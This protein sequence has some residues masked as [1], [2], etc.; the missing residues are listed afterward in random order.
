MHR[1]QSFSSRSNSYMHVS[2]NIC[3]IYKCNIFWVLKYIF[4]SQATKKTNYAIYF[5]SCF[6]T[7]K[8]MYSKKGNKKKQAHL[9]RSLHLLPQYFSKKNNLFTLREVT[10]DKRVHEISLM[11]FDWE[12]RTLRN[13]SYFLY[14]KSCVFCNFKIKFTVVTK[15]Q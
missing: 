8:T 10:L 9:L 4:L 3:Y 13:E 1:E 5:H 14:V 11:H 2:K 6:L 15:L 7:F 12:M